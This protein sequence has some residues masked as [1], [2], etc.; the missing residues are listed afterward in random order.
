MDNSC[1][2]LKPKM[3]LVK[4]FISLPTPLLWKRIKRMP[5]ETGRTENI[6]V[7]DTVGDIF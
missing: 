1:L 2:I 4:N 5:E 7:Q 3:C 6:K